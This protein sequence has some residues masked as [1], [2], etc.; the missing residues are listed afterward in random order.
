MIL[1]QNYILN[2]VNYPTKAKELEIEGKVYIQISINELGEVSYQK[3]IKSI[4]PS[5][6]NEAI[7]VVKLMPNWKPGINE[8]LV[9][10]STFT[11]PINFKLK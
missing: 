5:L 9:V 10:K 1:L 3:V 6:D 7:R 4:H 8:G 11:I 2:N